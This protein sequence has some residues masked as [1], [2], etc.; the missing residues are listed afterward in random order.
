MGDHSVGAALSKIEVDV[1]N[2]IQL[3]D[4]GKPRAAEPRAT[5]PRAAPKKIQATI[6]LKSAMVIVFFVVEKIKTYR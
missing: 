1:N 3:P 2:A 5:E 6:S 4:V